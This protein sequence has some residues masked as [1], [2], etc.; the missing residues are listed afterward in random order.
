MIIVVPLGGVGKRFSDKG[1]TSPKALIEVEGKPIITYLLDNLV[2]PQEDTTIIIPYHRSYDGLIDAFL[3]N[4]YPNLHFY[5]YMLDND[6]LGAAHTIVLGLRQFLS[7]KSSKKKEPF[8]MI[9]AD[10]FYTTDILKLWRRNN[11]VFTFNSTTK[12]PRFSYVEHTDNVITRIVEKKKISNNASC[13]AYC[14]ESTKTFLE[15]FDNMIREGD[16]EGEI[17]VSTVIARM[18][19]DGE[20]FS[21]IR[22]PNKHYFSLGTPEQVEEYARTYMFDLDGTLI[23]TDSVYTRVWDELLKP[24]SIKC[25]ESFFASFIRGN[26]DKGVMKYL[27]DDIDN[28][29]L[30]TISTRKDHLFAKYLSSLKDHGKLELYEGVIGFFQKIQNSRI[31]IVTSCNRSAANIIL[32][33]Y[34]LDDYVN[35]LVAAQDVE[36]HKP[37]PEPYK[38]ACKLLKSRPSNCI[39]FEDSSTGYLSADRFSPALIVIYNNG[40]NASTIATTKN[41]YILDSWKSLEPEHLVAK[42]ADETLTQLKQCIL[43]SL[44]YLPLKKI[45]ATDDSNLKTGY[46]CDIS[47]FTIEYK[48]QDTASIVIKI[49]NLDNILSDTAIKLNMYKNEIYFYKEIVPYLRTPNVPKAYSTFNFQGREVIVMENITI[50]PGDFNVNLNKHP[51]ILMKVIEI[52]S[53]M[54]TNYFF[55]TPLD[56][57]EQ[58]KCLKTT[59][60]ITHYTKLV[61]N[62]FNTF[63]TTRSPILSKSDSDI[64]T[65]I[66]NHFNKIVLLSSRYP[67]SFCHGDLKSP[68][69]YYPRDGDPIFLDWQYI[70]LNKGISDIAFLLL[71]STEYDSQLTTCVLN[72][73]YLLTK[74]KCPHQTFDNILFDFKLSLCVFPF[75][76]MIWF[77]TVPPDQLIDKALPI[78]FL[79]KTLNYYRTYINNEFFNEVK[80]KFQ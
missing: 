48:N 54:H 58:F 37:H 6:T 18:L 77:N 28:D 80:T 32:S 13:G 24:Y 46:I 56:I 64:L 42:S 3:R 35:V 30:E 20:Q 44:S 25:D 43:N 57:P 7:N 61:N 29:T 45:T 33:L 50:I 40:A 68:N 70:H 39:I 55:E 19:S 15:C 51:N 27:V 4:R 1:Y 11:C 79:K 52:I 22:I 34:D 38:V 69:I 74:A 9:D 26:A 14:F 12:V 21:N 65:N 59:H 41:A 8:I 75:F 66:F 16:Y 47:K 5:F 17:Y 53:S 23:S 72:Y 71:E 2:V 49:A 31:A 73:Y 36:K 76:V 78:R 60:D 67:L 63:I 62:N 10:N